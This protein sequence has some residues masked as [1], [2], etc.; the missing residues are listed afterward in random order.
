M[1]RISST[2][3]D[4]GA[5]IGRNLMSMGQNRRGGDEIEIPRR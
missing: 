4:T 5:V 1:P 2:M 3:S